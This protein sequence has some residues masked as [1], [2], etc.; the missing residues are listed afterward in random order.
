MIYPLDLQLYLIGDQ[1]LKNPISLSMILLIIFSNKGKKKNKVVVILINGESMESFWM[2]TM[3]TTSKLITARCICFSSTK[4]HE[5]HVSGPFWLQLETIKVH[6]PKV[7][8]FSRI[9]SLL[10]DFQ[11]LMATFREFR[12]LDS[13]TELLSSFLIPSL[14]YTK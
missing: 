13:P 5:S 4:S 3:L 8:T 2:E 6:C 11:Q 9:V 12:P 10:E 1:S 7:C 14:K